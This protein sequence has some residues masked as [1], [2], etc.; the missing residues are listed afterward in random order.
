MIGHPQMEHTSQKFNVTSEMPGRGLNFTFVSPVEKTI[1]KSRFSS[2]EDVVIKW[3]S[4]PGATQY[5]IQ[6]HEKTD[7]RGYK[8]PE[9]L[10]EWQHRPVVSETSLD[11]SDF[12]DAELKA[13]RFYTIEIDALDDNMNI[14]SKTAR[15]YSG[16]DFQIESLE[17]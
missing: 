17:K 13:G 16:Y 9:Q 11:L 14:L 6:I 4:Y 8:M 5:R 7:P 3:N 1:P 12:Y 10:F 15:N 2:S